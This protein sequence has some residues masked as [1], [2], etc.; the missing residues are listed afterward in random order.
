MSK[1]SKEDLANNFIQLYKEL[2]NNLPHLAVH[3]FRC[4]NSDYS[5]QL[6]DSKNAY[7]CFNGY[8]IEDGYYLY[9]SRWNKNCGD[10]CYSNKCEL[11]Y[12]C[13]DCD[14]CY[15][16]NFCQNCE[17][18]IDLNYCM[19]CFSCE[20]CFG[21]SGLRKAKFC[22]FNEKYSKEEYEKKLMEVETMTSNEIY[23]KIENLCLKIPHISMRM[24]R[25][26]NSFGNYVFDCKNSNHVFKGHDLEDC[27]YAYDSRRLKDCVDV[28]TQF[29]S[30]LMYECIEATDNYNSNFVFWS[31][32]CSNC[33]YIMYCFNCE[34]CFGCFD[35]KRK[36]YCILNEEY[37]KQEYEELVDAIKEG[38]RERKEYMNFLPDVV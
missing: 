37:S 18:C 25:S 2:I 12:E 14:D 11:C 31:A 17:R 1:Y 16:C 35:L 20:N 30:E 28:C 34:D 23:E 38:L 29:K 24:R 15:N 21:C 26:E 10:L 32:N 22:I 36:K 5:D 4:E 8:G 9:D 3:N 27:V 13:T 6:N 33:E 19:D 7:L